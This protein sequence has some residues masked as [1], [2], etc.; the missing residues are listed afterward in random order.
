MSSS[1]PIYRVAEWLRNTDGCVAP[2]S[3]RE[4]ATAQCTH[5]AACSTRPLPSHQH[6]PPP[7]LA[8]AAPTPCPR[9]SSTHPPPSHQQHR[10]GAAL[11]SGP[12]HPVPGAYRSHQASAPVGDVCRG[13]GSQLKRL[14]AGRGSVQAQAAAGSTGAA[15]KTK[16]KIKTHTQM[17]WLG[18][19]AGSAPRACRHLAAP[20]TL[21]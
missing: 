3:G 11:E 18:A 2:R 8:P 17:A 6:A 5:A 4:D 7:A 14:G 19:S 16:L 10:H 20:C 21:H 15:K 12:G 13:R 1:P 9:T